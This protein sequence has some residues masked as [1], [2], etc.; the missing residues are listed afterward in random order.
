M[1]D[2]NQCPKCQSF[3]IVKIKGKKHHTG[4]T[5]QFNA[6]ATKS[7]VLD[8]YICADCGYT[9]HYIQMNDKTKRYLE[10]VLKKQGGGFDEFV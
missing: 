8:R 3:G 10:E 4:H 6:W 7:G 9:E 2:S 1:R 5:V